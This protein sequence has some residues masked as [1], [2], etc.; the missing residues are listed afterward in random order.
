[1]PYIVDPSSDSAIDVDGDFTWETVRKANTSSRPAQGKGD[2]KPDNAKD[3]KGKTGQ[4]AKKGDIVL[5]TTT[6][7]TE[8]QSSKTEKEQEEKPYE[9]KD[10]K[11]KVPKGAF[12]AIVGRV[13]S[14]KVCAYKATELST[15]AYLVPAEFPL[16]GSDWGDEEDKGT[17]T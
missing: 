16:A 3:K 9:L 10:L 1:M 11:L 8:V 7:E 15:C 6:D 2:K 5:P 14:G 13:G 4:K 12:V 17:C